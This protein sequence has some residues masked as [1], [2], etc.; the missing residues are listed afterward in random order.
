MLPLRQRKRDNGN[1]GSP[2]RPRRG[3]NRVPE[4][5]RVVQMGV[6][7][8]TAGCL[9][10]V[11]VV[12]PARAFLA[13]AT[14]GFGAW[15]LYVGVRRMG[16]IRLLPE[17]AARALL[18]RSH[19]EL[20]AGAAVTEA[21]RPCLLFCAGLSDDEVRRLLDSLPPSLRA[22]LMR[23]G[24]VHSF[25]AP[26]RDIILPRGAAAQLPAPRP[27]R[28]PLLWPRPLLVAAG[29]PPP[30]AS[31]LAAE[32]GPLPQAASPA[33][34][35][36]AAGVEVAAADDDGGG[37]GGAAGRSGDNGFGGFEGGPADAQ[38]TPAA[39][40]PRTD[41]EERGTEYVHS[42]VSSNASSPLHALGLRRR[43]RPQPQLVQQAPQTPSPARP[44]G[45]LAVSA[46]ARISGAAPLEPAAG[47]M[48]S[49]SRSREA[50]ELRVW[51][52]P[53]DRDHRHAAAA[54]PQPRLSAAAAVPQVLSPPAAAPVAA[55]A[56]V[57]QPSIDQVAYE[58]ARDRVLATVHDA[59]FALVGGAR[60]EEDG[61]GRGRVIS[62]VGT[63]AAV[64]LAAQLWLSRRA[65]RQAASL[66][67]GAALV[68][69]AAT[70]AACAAAAAARAR[71]AAASYA[72][73][74][75][76][77]AAA[78]PVIGAPAAGLAAAV[79]SALP[80]PLLSLLR[81]VRMLR[82]QR[83]MDVALFVLALLLAQRWRRGH[84]PV[85]AGRPPALYGAI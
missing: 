30:A 61:G 14:I 59:L 28:P 27:P 20:L 52:R 4:G 71:L 43:L 17:P 47:A 78:Q 12:L 60:E 72:A 53:T 6:V 50:P 76:R 74:H 56:A 8:F 41:D 34:P 39:G 46:A 15:L 44:S 26:L 5:M 70:V 7:L 55:A 36:E 45:A 77:S 48:H 82:W 84:R 19:L 64:A 80:L 67:S 65:R 85:E 11:T 66:A 81:G 2:R 23:P 29:H 22:S 83:P 38:E 24:I 75:G 13:L 35:V 79:G 25:P 32:W 10:F 9:Y 62:V 63:T 68:M 58:I 51:L 42:A 31:T 69:L 33:R 21:L 57:P 3:A 73:G 49:A 18:E 54:F 40:T 16:L 1:D 37:G